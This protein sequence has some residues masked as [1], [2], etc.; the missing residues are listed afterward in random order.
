MKPGNGAL[1]DWFNIVITE[2][3]CFV[4]LKIWGISNQHRNNFVNLFFP[5][6]NKMFQL[7]QTEAHILQSVPSWNFL[8]QFSSVIL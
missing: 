4:L 6:M 2:L 8:L 7:I 5:D 1:R 3:Y